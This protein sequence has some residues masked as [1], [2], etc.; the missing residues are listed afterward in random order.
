MSTPPLPG[1]HGL[2]TVSA[3]PQF[4]RDSGRVGWTGA[5]FTDL[6]AVPQGVVDH[7]HARLCLRR[8]AQ[9]EAR[10]RPAEARWE[11]APPGLSVLH[12]GDEE[13]FQWRDGGRAQFLFIADEHIA[14]VLGQAPG[15]ALWRGR[16]D[17]RQAHGPGLV[18]DALMSDLVQGSP[19]GPLVGDSL[20]VAL[21]S[22]LAGL[23]ASNTQR[24]GA[25]SRARVT[26]V[27]DARFAEPLT[28][29]ELASAG[30]L[31][32]RQ[33]TR[34]FREATGQSPHQYLLQRRVDHAKRLILRGYPLAEVAL[35]CG[36]ADQSQFTRVFQ[37]RVGITPGRFLTHRD[38]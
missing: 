12:A 10:R 29:G 15:H 5:F 36:F 32:V 38:G 19:A 3:M 20:I 26:E 9:L 33:F 6:I 2:Y 34:A 21:L 4:L 28:L 13:R 27:L 1:P 7:A 25:R 37:R 16:L 8:S 23:A 24:M 31:S 11:P 35:Q 22:Q 30:G 18:L 14:A 17:D